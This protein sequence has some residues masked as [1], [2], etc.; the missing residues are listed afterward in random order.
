MSEKGCP[1]AGKESF[2]P[3]F[4]LSIGRPKIRLELPSLAVY[5]SEMGV[6][7]NVDYCTA[8]FESSDASPGNAHT[9]TPYF[10]DQREQL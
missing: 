9:T 4:K 7:N 6:M 8:I 5:I 10:C 3:G 2:P 1:S